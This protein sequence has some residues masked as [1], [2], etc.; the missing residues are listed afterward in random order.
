[1]TLSIPTIGIISYTSGLGDSPHFITV[2]G[3]PYPLICASAASAW[4]SQQAYPT[5]RRMQH[6]KFS[7]SS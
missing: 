5:E 1:M 3:G 4:G 6:F 7:G 2:S